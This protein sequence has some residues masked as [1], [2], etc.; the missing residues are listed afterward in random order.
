MMLGSF[1][2]KQKARDALRGNWQTALV[3]TFFAGVLTTALNVV[4]SVSVPDPLVYFSYGQYDQ[5]YTALFKVPNATWAALGALC[6]LSVAL[7]PALALGCDRYFLCRLQGGDPGVREGLLGRMGIWH[8]ALWLQVIIAVRIFLWSLLLVVPGILAAIR[9]SMAPYY[10]AQ[11]PQL[12]ASQA[13]E[14]SKAVMKDKKMA[15]FSL[16][17]SFI[18][19]SL[20]A[21]AAQIFLMSFSTV[22]ALVGAQFMQL[23]IS[24]YMNAAC[25]SFFLTV[26][27]ENGMSAAKREM[28][29]RLREMGMDESAISQAG[30]GEEPGGQSETDEK[31]DGMR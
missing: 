2:F 14:K 18:G 20:A 19:W 26:S 23:A 3:V 9:Y 31:G 15:Y 17:I 12:T 30:F 22:V 7:S 24:V 11:E 1:Y 5:F 21:N 8:K 10:L 27:D 16:C 28:R 25:A 4:Q 6:L 29:R 13:L